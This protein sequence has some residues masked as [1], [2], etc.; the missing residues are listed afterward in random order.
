[1]SHHTLSPKF[2]IKRKIEN[3]IKS[4]RNR[5]TTKPVMLKVY[6]IKLWYLAG[7][8]Y[9]LYTILLAKS[10]I[11]NSDTSSTKGCLRPY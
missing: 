8:I 1:M 3:K 9:A 11:H 7:T 10:I 4:V 6:N 2:K 5:L